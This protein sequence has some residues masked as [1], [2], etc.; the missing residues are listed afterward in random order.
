MKQEI[1]FSKKYTIA[2]IS[3]RHVNFEASGRQSRLA[4]VTTD[5]YKIPN[6]IQ[7]QQTH[8]KVYVKFN[9]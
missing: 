2:L 9:W 1:A 6:T 3:F 7:R 5:R 8:R 4:M